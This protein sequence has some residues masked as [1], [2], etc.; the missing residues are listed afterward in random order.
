MARKSLKKV[1]KKNDEK[2]FLE[3]WMAIKKMG[4]V[5]PQKISKKIK[6]VK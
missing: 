5:L 6:E 3:I 1:K 2:D 4:G